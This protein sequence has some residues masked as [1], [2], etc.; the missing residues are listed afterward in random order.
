MTPEDLV[1]GDYIR[2]N[3]G[4][5]EGVGIFYANTY[6]YEL[7]LCALIK[8]YNRRH[9]GSLTYFPYHENYTD[10]MEVIDEMMFLMLKY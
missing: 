4:A 9:N 8:V 7:G 6:D 2:I 3:S 1:Q 5:Y 10:S